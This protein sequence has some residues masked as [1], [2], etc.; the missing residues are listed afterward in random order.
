MLWLGWVNRMRPTQ[1]TTITLAPLADGT[2]LLEF[3]F[4]GEDSPEHFL[5]ENRVRE[6]FDRKLPNDGLLVNQVD[7]AVIGQKITANRINTGPTPGM[8]ILEG[9]RELRYV[10]WIQPRRPERHRS[11]AA[12]G[13]RTSMT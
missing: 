8:R 6:S 5:I 4:Q 7:E 10:L 12:P 9:G 3:W 13:A 11:R 2:P 1:D